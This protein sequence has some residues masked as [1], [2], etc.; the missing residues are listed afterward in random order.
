[1]KLLETYLEKAGIVDRV[2]EIEART[3]IPLTREDASKFDS[4]D[5]LVT[6]YMT[7][8]EKKCR[9]LY[10]GRVRFSPELKMHLNRI[11]L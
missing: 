4:L 11:S 6:K 9:K 8:A 10:M 5:K 1:M 2:L 3:T 7:L